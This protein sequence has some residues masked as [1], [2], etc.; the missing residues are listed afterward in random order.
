MRRLDPE[1]DLAQRKDVRGER[2]SRDN[3]RV[4]LTKLT[5]SRSYLDSRLDMN[6]P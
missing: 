3:P 1:T 2:W 6:K 5:G 4:E